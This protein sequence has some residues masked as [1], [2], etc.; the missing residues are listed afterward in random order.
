MGGCCCWAKE[1][2]CLDEE[3]L[4]ARGD[5]DVDCASLL[6]D[7]IVV[8]VDQ[9]L[10]ELFWPPLPSSS[11]LIYTFKRATSASSCAI[12]WDDEDKVVRT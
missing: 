3:S 10:G 5:D 8:L 4:L 2:A 12:L 11:S 7:K 9:S 6:D 1:F